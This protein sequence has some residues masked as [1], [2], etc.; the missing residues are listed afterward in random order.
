MNGAETRGVNGAETRGVNGALW[1]H[2]AV[3]SVCH[4]L[5]VLFSATHILS[6]DAEVSL[7]F[8]NQ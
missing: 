4:S 3:H 2:C 8:A 1:L 6:G 5:T 7:L